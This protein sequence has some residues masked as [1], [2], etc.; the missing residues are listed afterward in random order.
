MSNLTD[1][2]RATKKGLAGLK[3]DAR[4][5]RLATEADVPT[6][7][8]NRKRVEDAAADQAK[9]GDSCSAKRVDAGP[10][11]LTNFGKIAETSFGS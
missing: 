6:D 7:K 5:P 9:H 2:L 1:M 4:Q 11:S 8:N 3:Q 10:M